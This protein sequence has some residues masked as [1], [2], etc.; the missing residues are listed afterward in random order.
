[1]LTLTFNFDFLDAKRSTGKS[2]KVTCKGL[3]DGDYQS[4]KTCS[5]YITCTRGTKA[6]RRCPIGLVWNDIKKRCVWPKSPTCRK[7]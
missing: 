5:G 6:K 4:C 7:L 3:D 2:C 1:M